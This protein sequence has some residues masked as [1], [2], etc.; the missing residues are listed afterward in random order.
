MEVRRDGLLEQTVPGRLIDRLVLR[1]DTQISSSTLA[2]LADAGIGVVAFGGRGGHRVAHVLGAPHNDP[3]ARIAQCRLDVNDLQVISFVRQVVRAKVLR[4]RRFLRSVER[5][6]LRKALRDADAS[7]EKTLGAMASASDVEA[8][9]GFEG[10]AAAAYFRAYCALFPESLGFHA[11]RRRPPPDP[12]NACLSL[13]YSVLYSEAVK[14]TWAA[15]LDPMVGALHRPAWGRAS[16]ACDLMEPWRVVVDVWAWQMFRD[17][18]FREEHFGRDGSGALL[19]GKAARAK[20]YPAL[21][22]L[23]RNPARGLRRHALRIATQLRGL[24]LSGWS[25]PSKADDRS[26]GSVA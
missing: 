20:A 19:M 22:L 18:E 21:V 25:E 6:D 13:G 11:R 17:R 23:M 10:A 16:L 7:L 4:Q 2:A 26:P 9:R 14:A 3:R 12:V 5:P 8:I 24:P 1:A 15:G